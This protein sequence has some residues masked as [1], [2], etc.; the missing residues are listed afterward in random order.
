MKKLVAILLA[1][2]LCLVAFSACGKIARDQ[3]ID[4]DVKYKAMTQ[5]DL[6]A[7]K[8]LTS[9]FAQ[10]ALE[11]D[12]Q[13]CC[14]IK[15][16]QK[17]L[18]YTIDYGYVF[19]Y[20]EGNSEMSFIYDVSGNGREEHIEAFVKDGYGYSVQ[21]KD[22]N[23]TIE[24]EAVEKG[25]MLGINDIFEILFIDWN[26]IL[27]VDF[28]NTDLAD[29]N[30]EGQEFYYSSKGGR[31]Y[32]KAVADEAKLKNDIEEQLGVPV[33]MENF[34]AESI[35]V[36]D[37]EGFLGLKIYMEAKIV[38]YGMSMDWLFSMEFDLI[39]KSV[40]YPDYLD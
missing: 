3:E 2:V 35:F 18:G 11:E 32:I 13:K 39:E 27:T 7:I 9:S 17:L 10:S 36:F 5:A 37:E 8:T 19:T 24:K 21:G 4:Y 16:T 28:S 23:R 1:M 25:E 20:N 30:Q 15:G 40:T 26:D 31:Y 6:D 33:T 38:V 22:E 12:T 34:T 29:L 14:R